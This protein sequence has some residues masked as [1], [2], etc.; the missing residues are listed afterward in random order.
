MVARADN[1]QY[2]ISARGFNNV[3]ANKMLVLIDGRTVYTPLFSGVFW[4]AQ[5]TFLEDIDRIEVISGP[6]ATL[7]GANGVNGVINII[8]RPSASTQ[9]ALVA[10]GWGT[11]E[12]GIGG[13]IG[14]TA[15]ADGTYRVY[16]KYTDRD[17]FNLTSGDPIRDRSRMLSTG[18]RADWERAAET[19]TVQGDGYSGSIDQEPAARTISGGNLLGRW[20]RR[21]EAGASLQLQAYYD[22]TNRDHGGTFKEALDTFDVEFQ[23]SVMAIARH[24]MIWGAG[25]RLSRDHVENSAAQAFLPADRSLHWANIFA[26]DEFALL[27]ELDLTLGVKLETNIYTGAEYLPNARLAWHPS[28][29]H[30]VWGA[31]SHAVRA[32]SRIDRDVFFPGAPPYLLVGN[33][34]FES[35]IARVFEAG[36]RAQLGPAASVSATAFHHDYPNLRSVSPSP[37]GLVFANNIE[38]R[39]YGLEAWSSYRVNPTWR[40]T[41]GFV[42]MRERLRLRPGQIDLGGL[43][44]LANDPNRVALV[45]SAWDLTPR[46]QLDLAIRHAGDLKNPAVPAYAVLDARFGWR[47]TDAL[48]LSLAVQNVFDR[49]YAEW[50]PS[51]NRAR[52]ERAVFLKAMLKL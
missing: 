33:N 24:R 11:R 18:M 34:T 50:G 48:E 8:T 9:G 47:V 35:E 19:I 10:G 21:L 12:S 39:V 30:L 16:A 25:Y 40:L 51:D 37:A 42:A 43:S 31:Y 20:T 41:G 44:V 38:G 26:Q 4:E 49:N 14:A 22:R 27:D 5:D 15:F 2:A 1:T 13:R 23:H 6:A 46:H 3:L 36:Y 45:R 7:W 32:P 29:D 52:V 17:H 28:A